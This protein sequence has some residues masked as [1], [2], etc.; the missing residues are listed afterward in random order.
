[1]GIHL[2]GLGQIDSNEYVQNMFFIDKI[3]GFGKEKECISPESHF[4]KIPPL[5]TEVL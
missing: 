5:E 2:N 4:R 1:M 3:N